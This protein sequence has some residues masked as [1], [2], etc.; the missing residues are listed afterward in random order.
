M[1]EERKEKKKLSSRKQDKKEMQN[2]SKE[3]FC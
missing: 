2:H 3:S 1:C